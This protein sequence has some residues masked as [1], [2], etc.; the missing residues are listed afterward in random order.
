VIP[1]PKPPEVKKPSCDLSVKPSS[2]RLGGRATLVWTTRNADTFTIDN[3]VGSMALVETGSAGT[4]A[5]TAD[6]TFTGTATGPDG[7][8]KCIAKVTVIKDPLPVCSLTALKSTINLGESSVLSWRTSHATALTIDQGVGTVTPVEAGSVSVSPRVTTTYTGRATGPGGTSV[9][10]KTTV[11]VKTPPVVET[12]TCELKATPVTVKKGRTSVLTWTT[13]N[14]SKFVI[15]KGVGPMALVEIGSAGTPAIMTDTTFTGTATSK[16]GKTVTCSAKVTVTDAPPPVSALACTL[17]ASPSSLPVGGGTSTLSWTTKDAV[18]FSIDN[19]MGAVTPVSAGSATSPTITTNTTFTGTAKDAS[20]KT[21]S[22]TTA[23]TVATSGGGCTSN[24][25]GGGG[26]SSPRPKVVL[27]AVPHI[28]TVAGSYIYLSQV[29]YTGLDLGPWGTAI[30]WIALIG[31][32]LALAYLVLFGVIPFAGTRMRTFGERVS[33]ALNTHDTT[34][35]NAHV[36]FASPTEPVTRSASD[37]PEPRETVRGYSTFDG[38]RSFIKNEELSIEDIVKGLARNHPATPA[39]K[40]EP[41]YENVEPVYENV[42]AI[43][44]TAV[45]NSTIQTDVRGF[46]TS[47]VQGD[48]AAVFAGL[49]QQM[50]GDGAP[51]Q[52]L[53]SVV[54]LLD[55]VYRARIDGTSCD[56]EIARVTARLTTPVLEKLIASLTTAIDS[57]YSTGVTGAKLALTRALATLGA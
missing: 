50:R 2:V 27:S 31:W 16:T 42:E 24:C 38:F 32:S 43:E 51:E 8:A 47:L 54:C 11:T 33:L 10:C 5:I 44:E 53:S 29:P 35:M 45:T 56:Q 34:P 9:P 30:Y 21:V 41:V 49:R 26:G 7:S 52:L 15:D 3:G 4:P 12:L 1:P 17:S 25:G 39:V 28:G 40:T 18:S 57:S 23:V 37:T 14:A 19:G 36:A 13:T 20:G 22:C 55:D 6:I 48:R 46:T